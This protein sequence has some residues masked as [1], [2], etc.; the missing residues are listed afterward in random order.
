MDATA[1]LYGALLGMAIARLFNGMGGTRRTNDQRRMEA[2]IDLLL[3]QGGLRYDPFA[4][5][6]PEVA[7]AVR[8]G[9]KIR[10]IKLHRARTGAGLKEAKDTIDQLGAE[11]RNDRAAGR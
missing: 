2:K 6:A 9:E 8:A 5:V 10:A 7:A 11:L 4:A 3:Q 1:V